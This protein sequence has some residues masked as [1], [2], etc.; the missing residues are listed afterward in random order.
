VLI[1]LVCIVRT[2]REI[3]K[4]S[5][6]PDDIAR[7]MQVADIAMI[8][9][10]LETTFHI[11]RTWRTR[12]RSELQRQPRDMNEMEFFCRFLKEHIEPPINRLR[13]RDDT[14]FAMLRY[15]LKDR[16]AE[17]KQEA[18]FYNRGNRDNPWRNGR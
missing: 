18:N 3:N 17:R 5:V 16:I 7:A 13:M 14:L 12:Y 6:I 11:S 2:N 9:D 4:L 1:L 10:Y 15:L 8:F